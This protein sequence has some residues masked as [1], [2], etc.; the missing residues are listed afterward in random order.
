MWYR[1]AWRCYYDLAK[2][3]PIV[4]ANRG[5]P[6]DGSDEEQLLQEVK[7]GIQRLRRENEILRAKFEAW[8]LRRKI[9]KTSGQK[10][11]MLDNERL[12]R[13]GKPPHP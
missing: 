6:A 4:P 1:R 11:P 8:K 9:D 12:D 3:T 5:Y 13:I 10:T 2:L 7:E